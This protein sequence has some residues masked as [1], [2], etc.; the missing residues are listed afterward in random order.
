MARASWL[1]FSLLAVLSFSSVVS[2][3]TDRAF[4][5]DVHARP[6]GSAHVVEKTLMNLDTQSEIDAFDFV[7]REGRT[8]LGGWQKFSRNIRY[9]L[10][11][12]VFN[13]SIVGTREFGT[14]FTSA[15]V[16]LEYDVENVT[17]FTSVSS[18]KTAYQVDT[19]RILLGTTPGEFRLE[20]NS[21]FALHLPADA[22]RIRVSPE[23]GTSRDG[24][25]VRWLGSTVGSWE[26]SFER[27]ISLADEVNAF[28]AESY[29]SLASS[30]VLWLLLFFALA[31][32]G[33]KVVQSRR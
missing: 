15:S 16:T 7:V 24:P 25:T 4:W 26:V 21:V 14:S 10:S 33:Y 13:V 20:K 6:D 12:S 5:L 30:G 31:V 19:R 17:S 8:N 29:K 18:R 2:A 28:F 22:V 1:L 3:Y 11:G 27:E 32:V 23:A 9:H